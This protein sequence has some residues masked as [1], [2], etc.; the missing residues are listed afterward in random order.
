MKSLVREYGG[1]NVL[2]NNVCP[3]ATATGRLLNMA[4]LRAE[5]QGIS[6]DEVIAG[7]TREAPL[8]RVGPSGR[9]RTAG[10][11]PLLGASQLHH[12]H[13]RSD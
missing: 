5:K 7:M 10:C 13:K 8:R 12:G 4:S 11:V 1:D 6:A 9:V 2:F 3:G